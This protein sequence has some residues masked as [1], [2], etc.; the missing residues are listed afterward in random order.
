MLLQEWR[1]KRLWNLECDDMIKANKAAIDQLYEAA[2]GKY[3]KNTSALALK[4]AV[5]LLKLAGY[6]G[7]ENE[8][9]GTIAY[10]LSKMT[11]IDEMEHFGKYE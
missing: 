7:P 1:E 8:K 5:E 4:D 11:I 6:K 2:K 10:A 3:T 9:F